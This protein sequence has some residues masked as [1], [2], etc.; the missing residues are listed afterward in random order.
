M[1]DSVVMNEKINLGKV[2]NEE[3]KHNSK[4]CICG[5]LTQR[6]CVIMNLISKKQ[7]LYFLI[8]F[9]PS[10]LIIAIFSD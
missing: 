9:K 5:C 3:P 4:M 7:Y 8:D 2:S 10:L 1:R 6:F